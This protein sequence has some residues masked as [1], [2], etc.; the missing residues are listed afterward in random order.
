[1]NPTSTTVP[2]SDAPSRPQ[3]VPTGRVERQMN[4][5]DS[6]MLS[7]DETLKRSGV[8]GF[9]TQMLLWLDGRLDLDR[10][11]TG[12]AR[13]CR[14]FPIVN[15]HLVRRP[16]RKP[17]WRPR[18]DAV[19]AVRE[20]TLTT[21]DQ[22]AVLDYAGAS[23]SA[24]H[25]LTTSDPL[26]FHLLHLPDGRDVFL[27]QYN[28]AV[29]DAI[30]AVLAMRELGR[31]AESDAAD[32]GPAAGEADDLMGD[33]LR[34]FP[35]GRRLRAAYRMA[36]LRL[37]V[38]RMRPKLLNPAGAE[39]PGPHRLRVVMRDMDLETTQRLFARIVQVCR[40]PGMSMAL[41]AGAFRALGELSPPQTHR[42]FYIA[43]IGVDLGLRGPTG[44][45]FQNLAS[46]LPIAASEADLRDREGLIRQLNLQLR[47]RLEQECDLANL[48]LIN[49]FRRV[50]PIFRRST[51]H[52]IRNCYSLW[53][54]FFGPVDGVGER[55][56]GAG[57]ADVRFTGPCWPP[58]GVTLLV[59]QFRGRTCFQ[60]T[61][62]PSLVPDDL[63]RRFLDLVVDDLT[64][65]AD[66]GPI[67]KGDG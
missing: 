1:M 34:S 5:L 62:L 6:L 54:A 51:S 23:L 24:P 30:S 25:D 67:S 48:E 38:L 33:Y 43:G 58:L 9:E 66:E 11:R 45:I 49:L 44:P 19:P 14:R 36:D 27:L 31:L 15:A 40:L 64:R 13:L 63:A 16:L 35:R 39:V 29:M 60:V 12:L 17:Y 32:D 53:Y 3:R 22:Q 61:Y 21:S 4:F 56:C 59:N 46:L 18:P 26:Q 47:E 20:M 50:P 41:L 42:Q 52:L 10:L 28:H 57:I 8:S 2:P 65:F 37:R 55:L 7:A